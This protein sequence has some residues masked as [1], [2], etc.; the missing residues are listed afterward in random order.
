[1]PLPTLL[2][3][4]AAA[5]AAAT[6]A[7]AA[8]APLAYFVGDW[9]CA[10]RFADG[11]AIRSRES[12]APALD[13]RWL[14]MRHDDE[15]PGRYRAVEWWGRDPAT[16]KFVA[17]VFDNGGGVR[18]YA[19]SGWAGDSLTLANTTTHGYRDRFVFH[20]LDAGAYRVDYAYRD[21]A[22]AWRPGD[23]LRCAK[24]ALPRS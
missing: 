16:G 14:R 4:L 22:G 5:P 17:L 23:T 2:A 21:A 7:P 6:T 3:L 1:M 12:F 10:G 18:R 19:S 20:R 13:G 24:A 9:R 8:T 15:A 11:R